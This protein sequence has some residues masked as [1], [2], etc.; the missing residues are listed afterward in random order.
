MAVFSPTIKT[1]EQV[2]YRLKRDFLY[3]KAAENQIVTPFAQV[4][5][6]F[7]FIHLASLTI[8]E[9]TIIKH[10]LRNLKRDFRPY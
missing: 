3:Q 7:S 2:V 10:S 4:V 8:V 5:A 6:E 1:A 9:M